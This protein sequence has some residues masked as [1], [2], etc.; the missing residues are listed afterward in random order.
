MDSNRDGTTYVFI[1]LV[2]VVSHSAMGP[3]GRV[4]VQMQF[5]KERGMFSRQA[6]LFLQEDCGHWGSCVQ[7]HQA[8][9]YAR[10]LCRLYCGQ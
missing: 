9:V 1:I 8:T 3:R 5:M 6:K 10:V 4:G 7:S 2:A